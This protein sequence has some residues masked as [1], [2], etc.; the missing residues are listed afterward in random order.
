MLD[1]LKKMVKNISSLRSSIVCFIASLEGSKAVMDWQV[2]LFI[3]FPFLFAEINLSIVCT[4]A[5]RVNG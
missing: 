3:E 1:A 5:L 2:L 4:A